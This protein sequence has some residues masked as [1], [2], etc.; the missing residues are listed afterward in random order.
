MVG[1][2]YL[3]HVS[4]YPTHICLHSNYGSI[5]NEE[6]DHFRRR[7]KDEVEMY[8][9]ML[10]G[11]SNISQDFMGIDFDESAINILNNTNNG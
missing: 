4:I 11:Y 1:T 6:I 5:L 10:L 3:H 8:H 7:G 9:K 2:I